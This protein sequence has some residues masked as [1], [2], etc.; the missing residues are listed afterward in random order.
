MDSC[1]D[2]WCK[3]SLLID[4]VI[5]MALLVRTVL[6]CIMMN[7]FKTWN[8]SPTWHNVVYVVYVACNSP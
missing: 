3:F 6:P 5:K 2:S 1:I 7:P 4:F 8:F